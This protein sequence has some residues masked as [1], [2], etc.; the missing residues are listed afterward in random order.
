MTIFSVGCERMDS[1]SIP[2]TILSKTE[3]HTLTGHNII[4]TNK[5]GILATFQWVS[6]L[7]HE[8]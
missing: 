5:C 3:N 6:Y 2:E 8:H 4:K 7:I 1:K